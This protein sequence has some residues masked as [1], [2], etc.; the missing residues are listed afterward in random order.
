MQNPC[1]HAQYYFS[2][3]GRKYRSRTEVGKALGIEIESSEKK[4][5]KDKGK[6]K[7][8]REEQQ[9][10]PVSESARADA[11]QRVRQSAVALSSALPL[12][13]GKGVSLLR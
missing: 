5:K 1:M 8:D 9:Q 3:A 7:D 2:P 4:A 11:L 6:E 12:H 10:Q 13:L